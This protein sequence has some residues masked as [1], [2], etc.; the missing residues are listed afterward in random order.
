MYKRHK[1]N[2]MMCLV[3][4]Y[5]TILPSKYR[6]FYFLLFT[7]YAKFQTKSY[8]FNSSANNEEKYFFAYK[9]GV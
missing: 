1:F 8:S 3:I 4:T 2:V 5:S 9:L 7:F 6:F